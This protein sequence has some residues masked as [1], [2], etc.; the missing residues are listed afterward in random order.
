MKLHNVEINKYVYI[1]H[2]II[3]RWGNQG[4]YSGQYTHEQAGEIRNP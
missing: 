1:I 3:V 2:Y 4:K